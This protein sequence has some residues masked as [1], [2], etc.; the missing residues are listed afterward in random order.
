MNPR[1]WHWRRGE[2]WGGDCLPRRRNLR[3]RATRVG[4]GAKNTPEIQA[5]AAALG[6]L[7]LQE[8]HAAYSIALAYVMHKSPY[9]FPIVGG[10]KIEHL[11]ANIEALGVELSD[12]EID[13]IEAAAPFQVGFP[14]S[15]IFEYFSGGEVQHKDELQ[16]YLSGEG[17]GA[18]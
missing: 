14:L 8:G 16:R 6:K 9:V 2:L 5:V 17:G 10:R 1:V 12:E 18:F 15:M 3:R 13:E 11:K 7:L 4:K